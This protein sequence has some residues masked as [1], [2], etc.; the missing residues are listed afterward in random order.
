MT[1]KKKGKRV[2]RERLI[3]VPVKTN[4]MHVQNVRRRCG[5]RGRGNRGG[6]GDRGRGNRGR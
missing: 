3:K 2:I 4:E 6:R 5:A 1:K